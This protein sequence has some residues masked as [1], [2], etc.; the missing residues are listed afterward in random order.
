MSEGYGTPI[1]LLF[2]TPDNMA[3]AGYSGGMELQALSFALSVERKVGGMPIPFLGGRRFGLDLNLVNSTII[4]EGVFTDDDLNRRVSQASKASA[5]ID[6]AIRMTDLNA[7]GGITPVANK[8]LQN[9]AGGSS[10]LTIKNVDGDDTVVQF[11]SNSVAALGHGGSGTVNVGSTTHASGF[12]SPANLATAVKEAIEHLSSDF[13]VTTTTSSFAPSA[14]NSLLNISQVKTGPMSTTTN[15]SFSNGAEYQPYHI[16]FSGGRNDAGVVKSAGDKV[17]DLYGILHNTARAGS[18]I[19][20]GVI[21]VG[22]GIAA[23]VATGGVAA[24]A[25]GGAAAAGGTAAITGIFAVD[26][27][28]PIGIQIPYNSI[29]QAP[30]GQKYTVRNFLIPTGLGKS[31]DEKMSQQNNQSA[32]VTFDTGDNTTGIQGAIQKF[33]VSYSAGEQMYT[34]QMVF[35]P[36]DIIM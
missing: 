30:D 27:D 9:L 22:A 13:T 1:R 6:F 17:Q 31:V 34:Y 25:L 35:A 20:G 23:T 8:T 33:D 7:F 15:V 36:I 29:I 14:G 4:I 26:G 32:D 24:A 21:A 11:L 16:N 18:A 12:I 2:D 10:R 3:N 28:Y 5:Q 19:L